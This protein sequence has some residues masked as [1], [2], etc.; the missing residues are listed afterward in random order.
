MPR[1]MESVLTK[2]SSTYLHARASASNFDLVCRHG[3]CPTTSS[4]PAPHWNIGRRL[5]NTFYVSAQISVSTYSEIKFVPI[6]TLDTFRHLRGCADVYLPSIPFPLISDHWNS[7][8]LPFTACSQPVRQ[9]SN[10]APRGRKADDGKLDP[11]QLGC[12]AHTFEEYIFCHH[13]YVHT[14]P[15]VPC[16]IERYEFGVHLQL[17]TCCLQHRVSYCKGRNGPTYRIST[18]HAGCVGHQA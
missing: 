8:A 12:S 11:L 16:I 13:T 7:L 4:N 3:I 1:A 9:G 2:V 10:L 17:L 5:Q 15:P 6:W 18:R 14:T